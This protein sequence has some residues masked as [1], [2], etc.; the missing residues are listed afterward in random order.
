MSRGLVG[1]AGHLGV[2]RGLRAY[3]GV[4]VSRGLV[5][6]TGHVGVSGT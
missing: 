2:S 1:V 4:M 5:E 3:R 6:V